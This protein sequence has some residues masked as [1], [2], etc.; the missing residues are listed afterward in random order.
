M[1]LFDILKYIKFMRVPGEPDITKNPKNKKT[2][3]IKTSRVFGLFLM[4]F[5]SSLISSI[6][7]DSMNLVV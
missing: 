4:K 5:Y 7:Q 1:V 6:F 2:R 3:L